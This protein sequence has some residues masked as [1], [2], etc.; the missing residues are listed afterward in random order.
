MPAEEGRSPCR[1]RESRAGAGAGGGRSV[2]VPVSGVND[3]LPGWSSLRST[4]RC[5]SIRRTGPGP[6]S[7]PRSSAPPRAPPRIPAGLCPVP[8][9]PFLTPQ[10]AAAGPG[11]GFPSGGG[12]E[13][14]S[15]PP[16][17]GYRDPPG[18]ARPAAPPAGR[19]AE[20]RRS[21]AGPQRREAG[22][23]GGGAGPRRRRGG[24]AV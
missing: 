21:G 15:P 2:L 1:C 11:P 16:P 24:A 22:P 3:R 4:R 19:G 23:R 12:A 8:P 20:L 6:R 18:T 5:R 13:R 14:S 7:A 10:A 17:S 9:R